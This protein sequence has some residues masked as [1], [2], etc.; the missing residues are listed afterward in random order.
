M[1]LGLQTNI[2]NSQFSALF[3]FVLSDIHWYNIW[4]I[5]FPYQDTDQ[6][7]VWLRSIDFSQSYGPWTKKNISKSFFCT[8]VVPPTGFA[9][10]DSCK[11]NILVLSCLNY[12]RLNYNVGM[13]LGIACNTLRMLVFSTLDELRYLNVFVLDCYWSKITL[14]L[15]IFEWIIPW[16]W[17]RSLHCLQNIQNACLFLKIVFVIFVFHCTELPIVSSIILMIFRII[18][19]IIDYLKPITSIVEFFP[20][21][22]AD[23]EGGPG[24][25]P[26]FRP[27]FTIKC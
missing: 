6:V 18:L 17:A 23:L 15:A 24:P 11:F 22:V 1:A 7:R 4:F 9:V 21:P 16:V 5:A 2:T 8:F 10:S 20:S 19:S 3:S 25:P 13:G 14:D 12:F 26:P 27:K